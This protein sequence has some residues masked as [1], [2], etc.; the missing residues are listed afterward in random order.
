MRPLSEVLDEHDGSEWSADI[1]EE[2]SKTCSTHYDLGQAAWS[3]PWKESTLYEAWRQNARHDRRFEILGV[4]DFRQFVGS[5]PHTPA[6][7]T[8]ALLLRLGA[9]VEMWE[10]L[11]HCY[12][13]SMAGWSAWTKY[14]AVEAER[15][16]EENNDFAGLL[17]IRLAY[18]VAL[19]ESYAFRVNWK[20]QLAV[21]PP[22]VESPYQRQEELLRY[23]LLLSSEI[24]HRRQLLSRLD[25]T[26][27]H[28]ET[29]SL[30]APNSDATSRPSSRS[31]AQMVFCIDV[32]SERMRRHLEAIDGEIETFGFA[33]FFGMP[34]EYVA[35]GESKGCN[36]TPAPIAPHFQVREELSSNEEGDGNEAVIGKRS[37]LRGLR[38]AWKEFQSSAASCFAFVEMTGLL[39][40]VRLLTRSFGRP[41][42]S[43]YFDGIDAHHRARLGPSR[44]GLSRQGVRTTQ[45]VD[46]AEKLLKG[47]GLVEDF[48]KLVV[49][50]GHG[51]QTEN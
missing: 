49:F 47:L 14:Q 48:A 39:Y 5:L 31:F 6:E 19:S 1:L 23:A 12:S 40:G 32:R 25:N 36:H 20:S 15:R 28:R 17:A 37:K 43:T 8:A 27:A 24:A 33:G 11:L 50:C 42:A 13:L 3:S 30:S 22:A 38:K 2:I 9:P 29:S 51:S 7:A 35:I 46:L 18:E 16:G 34:F 44:R 21:A 26:A 10:E 41:A 4:R 45:Q